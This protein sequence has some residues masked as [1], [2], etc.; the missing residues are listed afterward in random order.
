MLRE[1]T[2][3]TLPNIEMKSTEL[4]IPALPSKPN[5]VNLHKVYDVDAWIKAGGV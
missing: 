2:D 1:S 5:I 3:R 4:S